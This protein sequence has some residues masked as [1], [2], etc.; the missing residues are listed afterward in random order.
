MSE[1]SRPRERLDAAQANDAASARKIDPRV[2]RAL[3]A[4]NAELARPWTVAALAK[5]AGM[6]RAAFARCFVRD[7]GTPPLRHL[8]ALRLARGARLLVEQGASLAEVSSVIGYESE[9]A[10]SRAFKRRFGEAPAIFR[11]KM[12]AGVTRM[13]AAA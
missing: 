4:M 3:A 6:S 7:V 12:G 11:R 2:S 1:E 5:V 9:F 8:V 10:F 13:R